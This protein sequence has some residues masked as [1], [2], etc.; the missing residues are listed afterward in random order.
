[1]R[2]KIV[3]WKVD[4]PYDKEDSF[5]NVDLEHALPEIWIMTK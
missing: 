2:K 1:M 5:L 3:Y 4:C